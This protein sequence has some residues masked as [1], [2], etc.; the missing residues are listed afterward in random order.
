MPL[1]EYRC[2][3][4]SRE[5]EA[6]VRGQTTPACPPAGGILLH[7]R[8][9]TPFGILTR[10]WDEANSVIANDDPNDIQTPDD[11]PELLLE[12]IGHQD[13]E[14][15]GSLEPGPARSAEQ[16]EEGAAGEHGRRADGDRDD[17]GSLHLLRDRGGDLD[18]HVSGILV[19]PALQPAATLIPLAT[20]GEYL[21]DPAAPAP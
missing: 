8:D 11:I 12:F 16:D 19:N 17:H 7:W 15:D 21:G 20:W 4:C 10:V 2:R 3:A 6:L 13:G 14:A 5:F 18:A 1:Y 9:V